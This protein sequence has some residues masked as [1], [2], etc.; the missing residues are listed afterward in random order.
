MNIG[1]IIYLFIIPVE[2]GLVKFESA[3]ISRPGSSTDP[4]SVVR[5]ESPGRVER[6]LQ[7]ARKKELEGEIPR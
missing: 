2:P 3:G 7:L 5:S 6:S 1:F 4:M